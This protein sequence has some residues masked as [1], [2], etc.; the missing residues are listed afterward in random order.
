MKV[1][2]IVGWL[3][4]ADFILLTIL[5]FKPNEQVIQILGDAAKVL[6]GGLGGALA[7]EKVK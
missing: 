6:V 3:L 5:A 2:N 4:L 7:G 1:S